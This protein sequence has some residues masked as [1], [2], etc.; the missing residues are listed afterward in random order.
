MIEAVGYGYLD[1]YF[2]VC[3]DHD[4][5]RAVAM[6][7]QSIVIADAL[8]EAYRRS[9]DVIQRYIFPGGFL[10]SRRR[11]RAKS[12]AQHGLSGRRRIHDITAHYPKTLRL[13]RERLRGQPVP[14]AGQRATRCRCS[15]C[16]STTSA[17]AKV[18]FSSRPSVTCRCCWRSRQT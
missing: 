6:L 15:G 17:T 11:S 10:P 12:R 3:D 9:V 18:G 7:L 8:Y 16:G 4:Q 13:W 1:R 14:V 5:S 2:Q